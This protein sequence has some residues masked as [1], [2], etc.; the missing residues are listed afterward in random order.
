MSARTGR[1]VACTT[2][3]A[4]LIAAGVGACGGST[5]TSSSTT[6]TAPEL[7]KSE[8]VTQGDAICK[9]A[10]DRFAE[11][12]GSPPTTP[13]EAATYAQHLVDITETEVS[14]LRALNPPASVKPALDRYLKS[15]DENVDVLNQGLKAAQQSDVTAYTQAQAKA[16]Q[17]QVKRLQ[18]AQAVGFKECSLPAGT[19]PSGSG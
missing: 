3:I 12:Q 5:S 4:A 9:D 17:G 7:T 16:A 11:L 2:A 13:E 10:H 19:A 1:Q 14:Q 8:L 15:L 18:Y 6:S